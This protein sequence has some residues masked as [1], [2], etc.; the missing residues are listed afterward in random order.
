MSKK[1]VP[2]CWAIGSSDGPR[3]TAWFLSG[4]K[5]GDIYV[6][7]RSLGGTIKASFHK[8]GRCQ[9]GFTEAYAPTAIRRFTSPSGRHWET[10]QL[11]AN[12]LVRILQVI[13]PHSELRSFIDRNPSPDLVWLPTPSEGSV[14]VMSIFVTTQATELQ[15][16]SCPHGTIVVGKVPTSIR[17]AWLVYARNP[18]DAAMAN[19]IDG[20]RTQLMRAVSLPPGTRRVVWNSREDHDRQVLE[21]A[22]D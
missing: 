22:C 20:V 4:N 19:V 6:S 21:F 16:S 8:D 12:P 9:M 11:P 1:P 13:V 15:L 18:I 2:I 17:T 14:A 3:S 10:W 7:V 5:K